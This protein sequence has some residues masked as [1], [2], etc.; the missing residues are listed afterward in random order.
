MST[1]TGSFRTI[2]HWTR[3]ALALCVL[4][5]VQACD[6][7]SVEDDGDGD[8]PPDP[9][10]PTINLEEDAPPG[11][12][13]KLSMMSE[14]VADFGGF[15]LNEA[16]QPV[17]YVLD[18]AEGR[19]S[20]V[21]AALEEV[22]GEG[23]LTRGDSP[24]RSVEDP[25]LQLREGEY[26]MDDL[27]FWYERLPEVFSV[28]EVVMIDLYERA[29]RLTVG[30][31]TEEAVPQVEER[32]AEIEVPRPAVQIT[33]RE[34]P[35]TNNHSLRNNVSPPRGGAEIS[36]TC[37][38]GFV[39]RYQG[40]WGFI[41]NSHC[42]AQMGSVTGMAFN[43]SA[44]GS[45]IGVE[46]ADPSYRSCGFLGLRSCRDSDAAFVDFDSGVGVS[47][48]VMRT[49][50]WAAPGN[51]TGS[52]QIDHGAAMSLDEVSAHPVS[53]DMV[54]KV[55]RTSGWTYGFVNRTC[56][57]G[58]PVDNNGNRIRVDGDPVLMKCQYEASYLSQG[59]DSG[60]PVFIW[61]GDSIELVGLN[62]GGGS[63]YAIFS[64]LQG[65]WNDF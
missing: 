57:T 59:G 42:T 53:G 30:V 34:P 64:P 60:S 7:T 41:T 11:L 2:V 48:D 29:N 28:E 24:R 13:K 4:I 12:H 31:T 43:Q 37:T 20:E 44:N 65:I 22:F 9:D 32:I 8:A 38:L 1:L 15:Y 58:R 51:G 63:D 27:L 10:G 23:I 55:G 33:V 36:G 19:R 40:D 18:P 6:I 56:T 45:Q 25:T 49:Q 62:W 14:Q 21:R 52:I 39:G 50:S 5:A 16:G 47:T 61:K 3:V 35:Q 26:A 54:D 46:S 17:V